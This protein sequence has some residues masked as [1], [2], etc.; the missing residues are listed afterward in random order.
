MIVSAFISVHASRKQGKINKAS[1]LTKLPYYWVPDAALIGRMARKGMGLLLRMV[2]RWWVR[3]AVWMR[4]GD[5]C[6]GEEAGCQ[7]VEN[8]KKY[9]K[10]SHTIL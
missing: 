8:V 6:D 9:K 3:F 10:R 5:G 1:V 7:I 4:D 2:A